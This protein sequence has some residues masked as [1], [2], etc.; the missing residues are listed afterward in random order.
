LAE[1][2]SL[3]TFEQTRQVQSTY[4]HIDFK[5]HFLVSFLFWFR[6]SKNFDYPVRDREVTLVPSFPARFVERFSGDTGLLLDV[7]GEGRQLRENRLL[8]TRREPVIE[9]VL[10]KPLLK[11]HRAVDV[12]SF[13]KS[14]QRLV[15]ASVTN[16]S[17]GL[18]LQQNSPVP[19]TAKWTRHMP[20]DFFAE[21]LN[22]C[23]TQSRRRKLLRLNGFFRSRNGFVR[24][25]F[26]RR[27]MAPQKCDYGVA[28]LFWKQQRLMG[29]MAVLRTAKQGDFSRS[30]MDLLRQL[31]PQLL[32]ALRRIES[33][34]RERSVRAD[35]EEFLRRLPLPTIVLR[36]NL[37]P[38]YQNNAA[39]D[40]C[41]VWEKG[42]EEAR[43]TKSKCSIPSEIL[44]RCRVLKEKWRTA[45]PHGRVARRVDFKEEEVNHSCRPNLRATIH[46]KQINSVGVAG[47]H[48][49]VACE[50]LCRSQQRSRRLSLF[51]L[52][53]IAR[54]TRREREVAQLVCEGRSNK[55]IA[56]NACLSLPTVKKH[57]HS[58]F[59]KLQ[60]SSRTRLVALT[61]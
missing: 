10:Q 54:L 20:E 61:A 48:F 30:E 51:R 14:V 25:S 40:F 8:I 58:V 17:I 29:V 22:R 38:I 46:L 32:A 7:R 50:N 27:Y 16:H 34:E 24:S 15:S 59:R 11:L 43:R 39:R 3:L 36:W 33:L 28:L 37:K 12:K 4:R 44:D 53:G 5:F 13:W 41:A 1:K 18:L 23:A 9:P 45:K 49:L 52:P 47:P 26:Y 21:P 56:Q 2:Q 35:L 57:L 55:E 31:Y 6:V 60:V 19:V 42:P